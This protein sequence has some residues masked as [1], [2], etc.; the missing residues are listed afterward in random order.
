MMMRT[1]TLILTAALAAF[2]A[3]AAKVVLKVWAGNKIQKSQKVQISTNL[4]PRVTPN[5]ILS[6]DGLDVGYDVKSGTYYVHKDL[7][8]GPMEI[9][10]FNVEINDIWAI[11]PSQIAAIR[12]RTGEL[13]GKL[14]GEE[15]AKT[16]TWRQ[17]IEKSLDLIE[18]SQAENA[19]KPGEKIGAHLKT[20]EANRGTLKRILEGVGRIEDLVIESGQDPGGELIGE[21]KGL[22]I[23]KHDAEA[24]PVYRTIINRITV[25]NTKSQTETWKGPVRRDLPA[26][27]KLDD[28]LDAGGLEAGMDPKKGV[29]DVFKD[30]VEVPPGQSVRFDVKI[31]DPWNVNMPRAGAVLAGASNILGIV[32]LRGGFA[33]VEDTLRSLMADLRA[34][35]KEAGPTELSDAYVAYYRDQSA[36]L[37]LIE[38]KV[39]RVES[40]LRPKPKSTRIGIPGKP[41]TMKSTRRIIWIILGF[42]AVMSLLFF[43]RWF[44]R[45]GAEKMDDTK[46]GGA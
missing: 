5:D 17:E 45:T 26:E 46:G 44:G 25:N 30:P 9:R 20:Y 29:G 18:S 22:A 32:S 21:V 38:Q 42:V 15:R 34:M 14:S 11:P 28:I 12:K 31:R 23:P 4:P 35:Q 36:R 6:L 40:A 3:Q 37:D 33:S 8:L 43:L 39:L 19:L 16:E 1:V 2:P 10:R 41:P 24:P 13:V 27:I 7:E